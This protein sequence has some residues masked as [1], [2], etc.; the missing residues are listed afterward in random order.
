MVYEGMRFARVINMWY[1]FY[2][3]ATFSALSGVI[4]TSPTFHICHI[5]ANNDLMAPGVAYI[6]GLASPACEL[7]NS[8][9]YVSTNTNVSYR[10]DHNHL[11]RSSIGRMDGL[12]HSCSI[13]YW[14]FWAMTGLHVSLA[15]I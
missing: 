10:D 2:I 4:H 3:Q 11:S 15:S 6:M 1:T 12:L 13:R 8:L 7:L 9:L 14:F 5:T